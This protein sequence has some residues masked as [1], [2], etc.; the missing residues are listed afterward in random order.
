MAKDVR[1]SFGKKL[2]RQQFTI[3]TNECRL[4]EANGG[5]KKGRIV[6]NS[7]IRKVFIN[8]ADAD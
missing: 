2:E 8:V 4:V 7:W 3:W 6:Q 5:V 1:P